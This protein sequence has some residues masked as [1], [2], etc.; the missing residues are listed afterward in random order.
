[1][2]A[3]ILGVT[4]KKPAVGSTHWSCSKLAVHLVSGK[5]WSTGVERRGP[6]SHR[7]ERYLAS[8]DLD[9]EPQAADIIGPYLN[10]P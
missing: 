10:L 4:R 1:L 5:M 9:Y 3:R 2:R 7:I 6:E 8:D